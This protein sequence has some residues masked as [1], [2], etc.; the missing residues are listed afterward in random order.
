M[1]KLQKKVSIDLN[2]KAAYIKVDEPINVLII[3]KRGNKTI[4]TRSRTIDKTQPLALFNEKF[5]MKTVLDFDSLRRQFVKKRSDLQVWK[6]D[7]SAMIGV[8]DF[9]LSKYANDERPQEDKLPLRNCTLDPNAYVEIHIKA[10]VEGGATPPGAQV[11][12]T[13]NSLRALNSSMMSMPTIEEREG[14]CDIREEIER[15]EKEFLKKSQLLE[16]DIE[17]LNKTKDV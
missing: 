17:V 16:H 11:P 1:N 15:K 12:G 13:P 3:W 4:D 5:Q 8:A 2:I 9:D 7:M 6:T 10:K 14:E